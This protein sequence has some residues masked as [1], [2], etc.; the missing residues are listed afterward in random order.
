MLASRPKTEAEFLA[1][2]FELAESGKFES[3]DQVA[4]ALSYWVLET[5]A[6]WTDDLGRAIDLRIAGLRSD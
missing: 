2:A 3:A 6:W 1:N 5:E 4:A